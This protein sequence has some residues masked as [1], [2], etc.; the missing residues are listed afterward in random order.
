MNYELPT[1]TEAK[2]TLAD[3]GGAEIERVESTED[4]VIVHLRGAQFPF[5]SF[6][7]PEA[8]GA[9]NLLKRNI[10]EIARLLSAPQ[11]IPAYPFIVL[12]YSSFLERFLLSFVRLGLPLVSPFINYA[13]LGK[14]CPISKPAD[15][16]RRFVS[17]FLG[18]LGYDSSK[19]VAELVSHVI[20]YD[21]AY[22]LRFQD[23]AT[24]ADIESLI[25]NPRRELKRLAQLPFQREMNFGV[26][27]KVSSCIKILRFLLIN[28]IV[29]RAFIK[30][31]VSV[32]FSRFQFDDQSLFW[33]LQRPDGY[34]AFGKSFEE[35]MAM[36]AERGWTPAKMEKVPM[37]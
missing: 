22:R 16:F 24:A 27:K 2:R 21:W 14:E 30:A 20:E 32:D 12:W 8:V 18:E 7:T 23:L 37:V 6:A 36:M 35:R 10:V 5:V 19:D 25:R 33:A 26:A 4:G 15:E 11:L 29:K 13:F 3:N 28:P 1:V 34:N 31:F 17:I 9:I